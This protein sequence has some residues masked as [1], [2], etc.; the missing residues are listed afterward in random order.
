MQQGSPSS[1]SFLATFPPRGRSSGELFVWVGVKPLYQRERGRGEGLTDSAKYLGHLEHDLGIA[2]SDDS[3]ASSFE[4]LGSF[5][6]VGLGFGGV[7][8]RAVKFNDELS[9][10]AVKIGAVS[11]DDFLSY[12]FAVLESSVSQFVPQSRFG[13]C[14]VLTSFPCKLNQVTRHVDNNTLPVLLPRDN[15]K[16]SEARGNVGKKIQWYKVARSAG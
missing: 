3:Q 10:M 14:R 11:S 15:H 5:K 16:S 12:K 6:V 9:F 2:K 13:N 1:G 7:V 8:A 4:V